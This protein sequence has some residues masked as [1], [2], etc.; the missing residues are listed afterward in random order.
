MSRDGVGQL[1]AMGQRLLLLVPNTIAIPIIR[2]R[3]SVAA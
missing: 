3:I 1:L 2:V